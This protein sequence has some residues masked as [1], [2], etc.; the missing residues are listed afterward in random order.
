MLA[1]DKERV[2]DHILLLRVFEV[3]LWFVSIRSIIYIVDWFHAL[4]VV[5]GV[6]LV[7]ARVLMNCRTAATVPLE[8]TCTKC[9]LEG[10][11]VE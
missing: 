11:V 6:A 4:L 7:D 5:A 8:S 2:G 1:L 9:S 10:I 3:R